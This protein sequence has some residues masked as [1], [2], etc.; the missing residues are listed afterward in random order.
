MRAS[1]S[2]GLLSIPVLLVLSCVAA[3][4]NERPTVLPG[5]WET[6]VTSHMS[7]QGLPPAI[8]N[9]PH[10]SKF[11]SCVTQQDIEDS[12]AQTQQRPGDNCTRSNQHMTSSGFSTDFAC[13]NSKTTGHVDVVFDSDSSAHITMHMESQG[14]P[15]TVQADS[16]STSKRLGADCGSVKPGQAQMVR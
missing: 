8:A 6:T 13:A 10:T 3:G 11:R 7:G 4:Q 16:T 2:I 15:I 9:M 1:K 5:L 12:F 14:G